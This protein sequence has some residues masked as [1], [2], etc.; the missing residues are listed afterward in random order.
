MS[1]CIICGVDDSPEAR[2]VTRLAA[3]LAEKLD[4]RLVLVHVVQPS[5]RLGVASAPYAYPGQVEADALVNSAQAELGRLAAELEL[6]NVELRVELGSSSA[7]LSEIALDEEAMLVIVGSRGRGSLT[8]ALLGSV[9]SAVAARAPCPVVVLP[10]GRTDHRFDRILC[11]VDDTDHSRE[12]VRTAVW[13]ATRLESKLVLV[14]VAPR[15]VAPGA[16]AVP[17]GNADLARLDLLRAEELLAHVAFE[18]GL[19]TEVERRVLLGKEEDAIAEAAEDVR[20]GFIVAGS[21]GR[22]A[23]ASSLLGSVSSSL[24]GTSRCPVVVVP[25]GAAVPVRARS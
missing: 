10:P 11:A 25:F 14:H 17:D 6:A 21:R 12:A 19:G 16:S 1:G 7:R 23:V 5:V 3:R 13:L 9:S 24:V 22:G 20:A 2:G 4:V 18:H 8:S 15:T